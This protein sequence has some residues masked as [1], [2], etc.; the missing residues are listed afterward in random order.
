MANDV[1]QGAAPSGRAAAS[2]PL[3][4]AYAACEALTR[5]KAR[6]FYYPIAGLTRDRRLAMCAVYA[7]S[8][9]A[10]DIADEP[11]IEDR[12]ARFTDYRRRLA[13][14]FD[15]S[16]EGDTFVALAD[17]IRRFRIPRR[18]LEEIVEGAEQDLT[19]AR[20]ATFDD[21]R[22]YC[23][24]VASAVGLVCIEIFGYS[25]PAARAHAEAL[26]IGMQLTNILRDV[27]EDARRGRVYLPA[28]ELARFGVAEADILA[29]RATPAFRELLRFQIARARE[30]FANSE[31]LFPLLTRKARFC[32]LAIRGL[33]LRI[34]R[35][36]EKRGHDVFGERIALSG[37][38]KVA[39][40]IGAWFRA[41][42]C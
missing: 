1:R 27:G 3:D 23:A 12:P 7:F 9:G 29:E 37:P 28:D 4:A 38:A 5:S 34:L 42:G 33:Y 11:G 2:V 6:N 31:G 18:P 41:W 13:A 8:R 30:F 35:K 10:D 40:V 17:A 24:K 22:A 32:P 39:C 15:G 14:A 20:Y 21:L 36:I 26:G 16:P 25:D 19:V